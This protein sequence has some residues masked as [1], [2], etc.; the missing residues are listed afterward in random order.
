MAALTPVPNVTPL[1]MDVTRQE[2]VDAAVAR[3]G[4]EHPEKGLYALVNNAGGF[5]WDRVD[6]VGWMLADWLI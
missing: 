4:A 2:E 5:G 1:R 3:I 6:L